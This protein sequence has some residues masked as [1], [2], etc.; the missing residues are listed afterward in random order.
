MGKASRRKAEN[1]AAGTKQ[2]KVKPVPYVGRPFADLPDEAQ[3]VAMR[4]IVPAATAPLTVEVDGASHDI[5]L[6]TVLPMA[7]PA[8]KR[9]NGDVF[10][11]IQS[12][13]GSGD[14]S[15]DLG[16][17]VRAAL[18]L[19]DGMPLEYPPKATADSPRMQDL[20]RSDALGVTVQ[21]G[22][23]FWLDEAE[24]DEEG[25]ASMDR[26][27]ESVSPTVRMKDVPS[28]YWCRIGQRTYVRW[29]LEADENRATDALAR[30]HAAGE[31]GLGDGRL[32][33]AFRAYGLLVPVWEVDAS[34]EAAEHDSAM[35]E[36]A[37]R[38]ERA[39]AVDTPLTPEERRARN[40][41]VS[42]QITLR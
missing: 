4:E 42:R 12:L 34:T 2:Q 17:V 9:D 35:G 7:W 23:D 5:T 18:A 3:W 26:A 10:V 15:R 1:K 25:R 39:L 30:L 32:L 38:F 31:S 22:F 40:G 14:A 8:M 16:E 11:A 21:E 20:V 6:A 33:G 36:L 24:L 19:P 13:T 28:A 27:N 37:Q 29:I 41:V